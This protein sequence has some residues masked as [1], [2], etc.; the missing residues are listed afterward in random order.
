MPASC[1]KTLHQCTMPPKWEINDQVK[2]KNCCCS[3]G[4]LMHLAQKKS[5]S[6]KNTCLLIIELT[7]NANQK[8]FLLILL[9]LILQ[10]FLLP[11]LF[12]T[13]KSKLT[14]AAAGRIFQ[15][16]LMYNLELSSQNEQNLSENTTLERY[17]DINRDCNINRL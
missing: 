11:T 1:H 10:F 5:S 2:T 16:Q 4:E 17:C 13:Q 8:S 6:F 14:P 15:F 3:L 7:K 12:L 9:P